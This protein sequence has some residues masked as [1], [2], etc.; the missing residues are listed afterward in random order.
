[1]KSKIFRILICT[2]CIIGLSVLIYK[3]KAEGTNAEGNKIYDAQKTV[4]NGQNNMEEFL[5][6]DKLKLNDEICNITKRLVYY[7]VLR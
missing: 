7:V 1:M 6:F 2:I 4:D 5:N 3:I